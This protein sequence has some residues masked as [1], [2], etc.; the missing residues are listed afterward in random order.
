MTTVEQVYQHI[1]EH[2]LLG[3][4]YKAVLDL[5]DYPKFPI[6]KTDS[7]VMASKFEE[8]LKNP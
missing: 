3:N 8:L 6:G 2:Q 7:H 5:K 1:M 4:L